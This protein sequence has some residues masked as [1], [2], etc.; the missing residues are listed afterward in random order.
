MTEQKQIQNKIL[1]CLREPQRKM[2]P[3]LIYVAIV[4]LMSLVKPWALRI[5]GL[6]REF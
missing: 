5:I 3:L 4:M 1:L 6:S 2:Y